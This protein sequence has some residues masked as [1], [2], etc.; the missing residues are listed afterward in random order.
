MGL[1]LFSH[2]HL[3]EFNFLPLPVVAEV[4][5]I[6]RFLFFPPLTGGQKKK[7]MQ[8]VCPLRFY[9]RSTKLLHGI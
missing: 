5:S 6:H 7:K 1:I 2:V 9:H 3:A 8:S 4:L